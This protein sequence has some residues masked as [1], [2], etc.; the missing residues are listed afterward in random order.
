M[1]ADFEN[2]FIDEGENGELKADLGFEI[3]FRALGI[4]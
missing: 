2:D 1:Q 4:M 3:R